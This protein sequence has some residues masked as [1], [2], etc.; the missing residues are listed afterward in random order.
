M[1]SIHRK[2]IICQLAIWLCSLGK[3]SMVGG[4]LTS[5]RAVFPIVD[6]FVVPGKPQIALSRPTS[7]VDT[8]LMSMR[9]F[10]VHGRAS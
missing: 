1:I 5:E 8:R 2:K 3:P 4:R 7:T 6:C 9:R 10:G